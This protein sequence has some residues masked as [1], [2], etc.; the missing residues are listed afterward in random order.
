[1]TGDRP[2]EAD[3]RDLAALA[4]TYVERSNAHDLAQILPLFDED[5][6]YRSSRVGDFRGRAAIG[7]MMAG[8][9][10]R[11]PDVHWTVGNY[12]PVADDGVEFDFLMTA[13]DSESGEALRVAGTERIYFTPADLIRRI[14]VVA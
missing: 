11:V 7:E 1:M 8:F 3:T 13:T 5:A 14:E 4:R 10:A 9:F 2:D 12:A 6:A